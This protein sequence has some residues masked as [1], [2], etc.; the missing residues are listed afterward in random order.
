LQ[1]FKHDFSFHYSSLVYMFSENRLLPT[2]ASL[3]SLAWPSAKHDWDLQN[4]L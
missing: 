2:C 3:R 1:L 4:L